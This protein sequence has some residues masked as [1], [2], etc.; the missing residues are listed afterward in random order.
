MRKV[1]AALDPHTMEN[2]PTSFL[3]AYKNPCWEDAGRLKCI[4]H[5]YITGSFHAGSA[6]LYDKLAEH[7]DILTVGFRV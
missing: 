1:A 3:D 7:P 5:V 2:A 6:T 4:P